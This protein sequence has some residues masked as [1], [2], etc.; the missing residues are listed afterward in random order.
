VRTTYIYLELNNGDENSNKYSRTGV[1]N[2]AV[3]LLVLPLY[4]S[5]KVNTVDKPKFYSTIKEAIR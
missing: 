5:A 4:T 1:A 3:G 2:I